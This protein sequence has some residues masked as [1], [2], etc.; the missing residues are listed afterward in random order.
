MQDLGI[1]EGGLWTPL[2]LLCLQVQRMRPSPF[3]K[4][5]GKPKP[6]AG[7]SNLGKKP[8]GGKGK[9]AAESEVCLP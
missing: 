2:M 7:A 3:H 1:G 8:A 4:G 9:A 5:S 6:A